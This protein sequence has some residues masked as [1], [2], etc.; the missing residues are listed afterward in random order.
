M[1]VGSPNVWLELTKE[2]EDREAH[3]V[4]SNQKVSLVETRSFLAG[5]SHLPLSEDALRALV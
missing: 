3:L 4:A 2:G 5:N 1:P